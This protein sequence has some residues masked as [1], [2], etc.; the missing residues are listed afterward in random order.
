MLAENSCSKCIAKRI[1][2]VR[3]IER[4]R[5]TKTAGQAEVKAWKPFIFYR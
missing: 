3:R 1:Q 2:T 5:E 4:G